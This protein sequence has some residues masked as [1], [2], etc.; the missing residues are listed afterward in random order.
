LRKGALP[1]Q[2]VLKYGIEIGQSLEGA[3]RTGVVHRDLKPSRIML[4]KSGA[5]LMDF[6]LA[7]STPTIAPSSSSLTMTQ[8]TPA[9][10]HPLTTQGTIVGTFQYMS[11]EQIEGK[12]ADSCSDIFAFG[13]VLFEMVTGKRAFEGKSQLSVASAILE[14]EPPPISVVRHDIPLALER[15]DCHLSSQRLRAS[16]VNSARRRVATEPDYQL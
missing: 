15:N 16:L 3:H 13:A 9:N 4:T 2:Q 11:P 5:K 7:K 10:A 12:E 14:R 1:L 8:T 6:G